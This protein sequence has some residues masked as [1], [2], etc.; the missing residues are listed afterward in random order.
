[1][2]L[3]R[4]TSDILWSWFSPQLKRRSLGLILPKEQLKLPFFL[5]IT[6]LGF[7]SLFALQSYLAFGRLYAMTISIAP[8]SFEELISDQLGDFAIVTSVIAVAYMAVMLTVSVAFL[9]RL[10]GPTV[11]L[12][13][14]IR[15]LRRGHYSSRVEMRRSEVMFSEL[16]R[17]LNELAET[18]ER[19]ERAHMRENA[20]RIARPETAGWNDTTELQ[21]A[22]SPTNGR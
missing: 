15:E 2:D 16:S 21:P 20:R 5:L 13:R 18:L 1:M 6:T 3:Q 11:A 14:Q 9:H 17:E 19:R 8:A 12:R 4:S 7:A 22:H 10:M